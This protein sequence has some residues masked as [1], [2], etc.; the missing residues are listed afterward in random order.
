MSIRGH[1]I[2]K[3][4]SIE[5]VSVLLSNYDKKDIY[6]TNHTF[7][8]LNEKQRKVFKCQDIIDYLVHETPIFVGIQYNGN[9]ALFYKDKNES[10]IIR[11]MVDI[12]PTKIDVVTFYIIN[13]NQ[14][15]RH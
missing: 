11:I 10:R 14:I 9:H 8:R 12:L 13:E 4:L 1:W 15:P 5:E 7:F 2:E 6:C 3:K